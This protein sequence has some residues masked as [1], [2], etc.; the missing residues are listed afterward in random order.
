MNSLDFRKMNQALLAVP[1][2]ILQAVRRFM[3]QL[4]PCPRWREWQGT[5]TQLSRPHTQ[6]TGLEDI[7]PLRRCESI[8][9]YCYTS[10][11]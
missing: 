10:F 8:A 3:D 4:P 6:I 7:H 2:A 5:A 9:S 11:I 1:K